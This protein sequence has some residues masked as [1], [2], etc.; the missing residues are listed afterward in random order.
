[1]PQPNELLVE[2]AKIVGQPDVLPPTGE[3]DAQATA[4]RG[5]FSEKL[6][7]IAGWAGDCAVTVAVAVK[8]VSV[9]AAIKARE[10][11]PVA[12]QL[13]R[14]HGPAAAALAVEMGLHAH[15]DKKAQAMPRG[16]LGG[17][18]RVSVDVTAAAAE[19]HNGRRTRT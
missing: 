3:A 15:L 7:K 6:A 5:S 10:V 19:Y 8:D 14:E 4:E 12:A 9:R 11:A 13:V 2:K 17:L 18:A 16:I 1:M